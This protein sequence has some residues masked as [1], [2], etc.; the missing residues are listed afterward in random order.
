MQTS[1]LLAAE[2]FV[3]MGINSFQAVKAGAIPYPGTLARTAAAYCIISLVSYVDEDWA[4]LLGAGFLLA[5]LIVQAS[6]GWQS[7]A[8][9][10]PTTGNYFYMSLSGGLGAAGGGAAGL[11]A[12]PAASGLTTFDGTRENPIPNPDGT[13]G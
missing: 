8:A 12:G 6:N 3:A 2:C 4:G 7:F 9:L 11:A 13:F 1:R 10:A 5:L